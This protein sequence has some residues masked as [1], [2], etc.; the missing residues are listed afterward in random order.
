MEDMKVCVC[1][2]LASEGLCPVSFKPCRMEN[3][4]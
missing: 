4:M 2:R 3:R 1:V